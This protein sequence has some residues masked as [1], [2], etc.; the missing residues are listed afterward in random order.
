MPPVD[1]PLHRNAQS[2]SWDFTGRVG[3]QSQVLE[4]LERQL[5]N[6]KSS[7][8]FQSPDSVL[9]PDSPLA[10]QPGL[11]KQNLN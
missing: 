1:H 2:Y 4:N 10:F 9:R 11:A 5:E 3:A 7:K 6:L 8:A